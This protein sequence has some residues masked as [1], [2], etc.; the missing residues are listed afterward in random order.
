MKPAPA[1]S[2]DPSHKRELAPSVGKD[3]GAIPLERIPY[4]AHSTA[5]VRVMAC[6]P[7]LAAAEWMTPGPAPEA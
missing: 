7:A 5:S 1:S 4:W 2:R 6:T 3:P